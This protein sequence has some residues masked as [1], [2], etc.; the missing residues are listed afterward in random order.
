MLQTHTETE[1]A[2]LKEPALL[3]LDWQ[4]R[5]KKTAKLDRTKPSSVA[6][7]GTGT[8]FH[9][10]LWAHW[11]CRSE[12]ALPSRASTT[13]DELAAPSGKEDELLVII[14]QRGNKGLTKELLATLS[15]KQRHI[16]ISAENSPMGSHPF[17]YT[18]PQETSNAHT[19]SLIGAMGACSE[20]IASL[21]SKAAA[22]RLRR[23]RKATAK[24]I[25]AVLN[26]AAAPLILDS[27]L[28]R[29]HVVGGGPFHPVALELAL[30]AREMAHSSAQGYALEEILHGPFTSIEN[31][32][33]IILLEPLKN[34]T[35]GLTKRLY[36]NRAKACR[37][38]VEAIGSLLI[39]PR[40][41]RAVSREGAKLGLAWQ[42]LLPLAWGQM[43]FLTHSKHWGFDPDSNRQEDPRYKDA[44]NA[45]EYVV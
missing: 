44:K 11:L 33:A 35:S 37:Q 15:K 19:M 39:G 45:A 17:I 7:I 41:P 24:L 31:D 6:F 4:A 42:A 22:D 30:K 2:I 10:A 36:V 27:A 14:S 20:I 9:A 28:T 18:S 32:D 16:V 29:L 21:L 25:D 34:P 26:E 23:E 12:N 13:W 3:A 40:W 8:S 38:A 43:F 1:I 5:L